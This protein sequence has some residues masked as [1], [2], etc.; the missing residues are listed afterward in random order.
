MIQSNG[1][2]IHALELEE[3]ILL[4]RPYK[5]NLKAL[6]SKGNQKQNKKMTYRIGENIS[7]WCDQQGSGFQNIQTAHITQYQ[8]KAIQ[9]KN[10]K[11]IY[12][13]YFSKV[14]PVTNRYIKRCLTSLII[15]EMQFKT[16]EW[17][18]SKSL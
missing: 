15:K 6:H 12:N 14:I 9:W 8:K 4:K 16:T 1:K 7:E 2:T 10:R 5:L 13:R 18:S 17:P 3:W 11:K